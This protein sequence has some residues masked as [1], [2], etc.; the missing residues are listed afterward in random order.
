MR[1]GDSRGRG[2]Y[3][4]QRVPKRPASGE[5]TAVLRY[6]SGIVWKVDRVACP[7]LIKK[8][9]DSEA[10]FLFVPTDQVMEVVKEDGA[11]PF[12]VA[13]V[14]L[15]HHG[16]ECSFDAIVAKYGLN[17]DP[18]VALLANTLATGAT[19]T[20]LRPVP[21]RNERR[22]WRPVVTVNPSLSCEA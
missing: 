16:K 4:R 5:P 13:E 20:A 22:L 6:G 21:A 1:K 14:E 11:I 9:V 2:G 7:W 10:E 3:F 15:G 12:D 18:A 8:S 17:K 19:L